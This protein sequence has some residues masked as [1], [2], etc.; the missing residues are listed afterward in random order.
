MSINL[1]ISLRLRGTAGRVLGALKLDVVV[2]GNEWKKGKRR[3][4]HVSRRFYD[5]SRGMGLQRRPWWCDHKKQHLNLYINQQRFPKLLLGLLVI[6][7]TH[8]FP[9]TQAV[10]EE[11]MSTEEVEF[12]EFLC[13]IN[14]KPGKFR[15]PWW[16]RWECCS[17]K[18]VSSLGRGGR[19]CSASL[20]LLM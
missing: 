6:H 12:L 20:F 2:D 4:S 1:L 7:C 8:S 9:A 10:Y 16:K 19:S 13:P 3:T 11:I 18:L 5:W 17:F 14:A 15:M